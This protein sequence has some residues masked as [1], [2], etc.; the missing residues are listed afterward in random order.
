M[1]CHDEVNR[2]THVELIHKIM[3]EDVRFRETGKSDPRYLANLWC[4]VFSQRQEAA[5]AYFESYYRNRCLGWCASFRP[6]IESLG[7]NY[8]MAFDEIY[9]DTLCKLW[10]QITPI[11]L[12]RYQSP[13]AL[14]VY[15]KRA[16]GSTTLDYIRKL[17]RRRNK[18]VLVHAEDEGVSPAVSSPAPSPEQISWQNERAQRLWG[19]LES[20]GCFKN[21]EERYIVFYHF[22]WDMKRRDVAALLAARHDIHLSS[23]KVGDKLFQ[24]LER[25]RKRPPSCLLSLR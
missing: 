24:F 7:G 5:W 15:F 13:W 6:K 9:N 4:R 25:L 11:S 22:V 16:V 14:N 18:E 17:D 10:Q 1:K 21:E 12:P 19:C 20:Q 2:L 3:R 23:R 8:T